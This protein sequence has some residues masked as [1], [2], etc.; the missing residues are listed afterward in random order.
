MVVPADSV[1]LLDT[2]SPGAGATFELT[3]QALPACGRC[4]PPTPDVA[5]PGGTTAR[6]WAGLSGSCTLADRGAMC[7]GGGGGVGA[8]RRQHLGDQHQGG[9]PVPGVTGANE[10]HLDGVGGHALTI[11]CMTGRRLTPA[12]PAPGRSGGLGKARP[13]WTGS[14]PPSLRRAPDRGPSVAS[15]PDG[16]AGRGW[17]TDRAASARAA[18]TGGSGSYWM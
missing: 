7:P 3:D 18:Y 1:A 5:S 17:R 14:N 10:P 4:C 8:D 16:R 2:T 6:C 13:T 12:R 11:L 9:V 15:A